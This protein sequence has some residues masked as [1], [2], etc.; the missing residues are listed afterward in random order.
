MKIHQVIP[1]KPHPCLL[2]QIEKKSAKKSANF[3]T[4]GGKIALFLVQICAFFCATNQTCHTLPSGGE[5]KKGK[6]SKGKRDEG[7]SSDSG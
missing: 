3:S 7:S 2:Y 5:E 6:R 4:I 1:V